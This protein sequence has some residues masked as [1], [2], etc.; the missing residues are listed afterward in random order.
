MS[1][2]NISPIVD[3]AYVQAR[4]SPATDSAATQAMIDSNLNN[5]ITFGGDV[6]FDSSGAI[7]FDNCNCNYYHNDDN[8]L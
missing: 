3:S 5:N 7:L 4:Q 8:W 2:A 1:E 6:I